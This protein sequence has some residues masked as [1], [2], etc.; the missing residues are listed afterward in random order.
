MNKHDWWQQYRDTYG[1]Q[2]GK[3]GIPIAVLE[4]EQRLK[5]FLTLGVDTGTNSQLDQLEN[6]DFWSLFQ[7]V[8]STFDYEAATFTAFERRRV[9]PKQ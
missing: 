9:G 5:D 2:Y 7:L 4:S 3:L 6:Q 8:T 1:S